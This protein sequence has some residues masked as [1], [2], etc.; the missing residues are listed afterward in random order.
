M[1]QKH[2]G[3]PGF[4]RPRRCAAQQY[5]PPR[6]GPVELSIDD[7]ASLLSRGAHEEG[8]NE[9]LLKRV[10]HGWRAE[11]RGGAQPLSRVPTRP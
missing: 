4:P 7:D 8:R 5:E 11:W 9:G 2:G 6:R 10:T 1:H 3:P